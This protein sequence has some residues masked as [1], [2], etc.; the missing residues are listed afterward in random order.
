MGVSHLNASHNEAVSRGNWKPIEHEYARGLWKQ[1]KQQKHVD[2]LDVV[3]VVFGWLLFF[4]DLH[5]YPCLRHTKQLRRSFE[6]FYAH[7]LFSNL[8]HPKALVIPKGRQ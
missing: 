6:T 4:M 2:C 5:I 7:K 1:T 8:N 3:R